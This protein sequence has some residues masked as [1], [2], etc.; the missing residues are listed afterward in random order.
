MWRIDRRFTG[1]SCTGLM[2]ITRTTAIR[3]LGGQPL[4]QLQTKP[5]NFLIFIKI[6]KIFPPAQG[7]LRVRTY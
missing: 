3:S 7:V 5:F 2:H 1:L 6:Y 4:I